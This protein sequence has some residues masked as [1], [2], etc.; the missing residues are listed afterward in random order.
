[1]E[2][3]L[4][5][6]WFVSPNKF[7]PSLYHKVI[8]AFSVYLYR[9]YN[10]TLRNHFYEFIKCGDLS[11][12]LPRW[13]SLL[14]F[15]F[16]SDHSIKY[17]SPSCIYLTTW[18]CLSQGC[19]V[20]WDELV[21]AFIFLDAALHIA[22]ILR[23][24]LKRKCLKAIWSSSQAIPTDICSHIDKVHIILRILLSDVFKFAHHDEGLLC[25]IYSVIYHKVGAP[26]VCILLIKY[27]DLKII[28]PFVFSSLYL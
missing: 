19:V 18:V 25:F 3:T 22:Q 20:H 8:H 5:V 26:V 23:I 15:I 2:F 9:S 7:V 10:S 4:D 16:A 27:A 12:L 28:K 6:R 24:R 1:M 13:A 11:L 17:V 14:L 21:E